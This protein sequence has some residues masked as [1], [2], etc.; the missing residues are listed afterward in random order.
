MPGFSRLRDASQDGLGL[1]N[2]RGSAGQSLDGKAAGYV[3][4][5]RPGLVLATGGRPVDAGKGREHQLPPPLCPLPPPPFPEF[6]P[7]R[8]LAAFFWLAPKLK[9][10]P[11]LP[12]DCLR[13][14][15][16]AGMGVYPLKKWYATNNAAC[17][18]IPVVVEQS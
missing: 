16:D 4:G 5:R 3:V 2:H 11:P 14:E 18:P 17:E 13:N 1:G 15:F 9:E 12:D 8:K 7:P 10:P 6:L